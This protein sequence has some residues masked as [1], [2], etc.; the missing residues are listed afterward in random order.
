MVPEKVVLKKVPELAP[1]K[2]GPEKVSVSG[3]EKFATGN[4]EFPGT[5]TST[6]KLVPEFFLPNKV[7]VLEQNWVPSHSCMFLTP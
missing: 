7:P 3:P 6:G 4:G 1:V 5:T 2:F